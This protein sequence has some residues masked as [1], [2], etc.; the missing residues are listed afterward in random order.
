MNSRDIDAIMATVERMAGPMVES[1]R[2][3]LNENGDTVAERVPLKM[4]AQCYLDRADEDWTWVDPEDVK[5][6]ARA[7]LT[8][9]S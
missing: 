7:V 4:L 2:L 9:K 8:R 6:L 1:Q 3:V 5:R